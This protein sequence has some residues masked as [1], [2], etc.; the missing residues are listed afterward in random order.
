MFTVP[1]AELVLNADGSIYHLHLHPEDI[2]DIILTV[3]DPN[4][5]AHVSRYFDRL[6]VQTAKREFI[7]HTGWLGKRRITVISSGIGT[8]NIDIVINELDAA[9]NF[10]LQTRQPKT[11][12][13]QLTFLRVG[14][15]G[16][17]Q[18]D[19]HPGDLVVSAYAVGFDNLMLFY[20]CPNKLDE[21]TLYDELMAFLAE[22][23]PVPVNP[24]VYSAN[25]AMLKNFGASFSHGITITCPGF[26]GPQ[27]RRLRGTNLFSPQQ[28]NSLSRFRFRDLAITNLEMETSAI[29][30]LCSMLGHRGLACNV[31]LANRPAGTFSKDPDAEVEKLIKTVIEEIDKGN[32]D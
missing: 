4:R 20:D 19:L 27:A 17:L 15:S 6:D 23:G 9:V 12:K 29:F 11:E 14:T 10:D 13:R 1:D 25:S 32:L 24:Y 2:A 26:Y 16:S 18:P 28:M 7:T 22:T 5:V 8:D 21:L 30:G 31:L 3:G